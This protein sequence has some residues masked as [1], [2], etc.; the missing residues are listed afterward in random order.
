LKLQF[1][2]MTKIQVQGHRSQG[3]MGANPPL[4]GKHSEKAELQLGSNIF[5]VGQGGMMAGFEAK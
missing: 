1:K 4:F 3:T 5:S 2:K